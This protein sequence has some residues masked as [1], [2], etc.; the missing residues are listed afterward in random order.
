MKNEKSKTLKGK[1]V[2]ITL[3]LF[4]TVLLLS[5]FIVSRLIK[6]EMETVLLNKS[7]ETA[8]EI[9]YEV[10]NILDSKDINIEEL[11]SFVTTKSDQSNI[12]YAVIIDTNVKSIA[13]S[14]TMKIGKVYDDAY[15]IDGAKNG[16]I[17][18]SR[19]YADVQKDWTYDIMI[20]IYKNKTLMG[21]LDIGI[22]ES[23][24]TEV[25]NKVLLIQ[26]IILI[27]SLII[28]SA[29]LMII[30]NKALSPLNK[31]VVGIDKIGKFDFTDSDEISELTKRQDEIGTIANSIANMRNGVSSLIKGIM[32]NSQNLRSSSE[33]LSTTMDELTSTIVIIDS[34][35]TTIANE[36]QDSNAA[37]EEISAS[38]EEVDSNIN[39]LSQK[40]MEGSNNSIVA[41]ERATEVKKSSGKA[42]EDTQKLYAEKKNNML[43]AIEDGK[44]VDS[45]KVMADTISSIAAQ[46]NLLALNAAIEAARAGEQGRG[47]AVVADEVRKLAQQSSEAVTSIQDTIALVQDAFKSSTNTGTDLLQF[48]NKD[49]N[50]QFDAYGET[51]NQYFN[52]SAFSS[53]MSEEIAAM[54]EEITATVGQVSEAVQN[55]AQSSQD[56]T[57]Q[58]ETIKDSMDKTTKAIGQVALITKNQMGLAQTLN[59]MVQKFKI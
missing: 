48:I 57:E 16:N 34:A 29:L 52:D 42:I 44:V 18:T 1:L 11:Q 4:L 26:S 24:I 54:S 3:A 33:E 30:F 40:A 51:G 10:N 8:E 43:K 32:D 23:G 50:A 37:T 39:E 2:F 14:D 7:L 15:T 45:I 22:P 6:N 47:F 56:A 55:M 58:A 53:K 49:V 17:K 25:V 19:F 28:L 36:M 9:S 46:T 13:H 27:I 59:E 21:A 31:M 35:V 12:T 5:T 41:K 20:P 38:I